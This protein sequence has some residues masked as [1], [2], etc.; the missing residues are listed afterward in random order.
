MAGLI[1]TLSG[2]LVAA[3]GL[4]ELPVSERETQRIPALGAVRLAANGDGLSVTA[5]SFDGTITTRLEA[6]AEGEMAVPLARLAGLV[7]HFQADAEITITADD[8]GATI[9]SGRSKFR[10][11]VIP[12][13]DL[14]QTLEL[15]EATGCVEI[16]VKAARDLFMRPQ[17]AVSDEPTRYY[18]NGIFLHHVGEDLVAAASDGARVCFTTT[19]ATAVL[20]MDRSLVVRR[21]SAKVIVRLLANAGGNVTLRR[22]SR[23]FAIQGSGFSLVTRLVDAKFPSFEQ[24]ISGERPNVVITSRTRLAES[25]ARFRAVADPLVRTGRVTLRW[26]AGGLHLSSHDN[27]E[28]LAAETVGEASTTIQLPH[29]L[30]LVAAVRGDSIRLAASDPRSLV[31]INDPDDKSFAAFQSPLM[32]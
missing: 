32:W 13:E 16:E 27:T 28:D 31:A 8:K 6:A 24:M 25:L 5:T 12:L 26:D 21:E 19:P 20:S 2:S 7:A 9:T 22:S 10:L 15:G 17:F 4:A 1:K 3:L 18:L 14:P 23:L 11:P 30:D 29:L